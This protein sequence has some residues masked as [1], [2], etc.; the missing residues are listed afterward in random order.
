VLALVMFL[1][2]G[3]FCIVQLLRYVLILSG[4]WKGPI[5]RLYQ[6]YAPA[7]SVFDP[8][9]QLL[10]WSGALVMSVGLILTFVFRVE[11]PLYLIGIGMLISAFAL[12]QYHPAW[13]Y[14]S[15]LRLPAWDQQLRTMTTR[16]ERRHLAYMWLQLP[17][18][19]RHYLN[20]HDSAFWQ[21][22]ELV[23]LS[24][25]Q[26][27]TYDPRLETAIQRRSIRERTL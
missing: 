20:D 16:E 2:L 7:E 4:R 5:F 1:G 14:G 8:L 15:M 18:R 3:L 25:V 13:R 6:E 10:C 23:I 26:Q 21:W 12:Y 19:T 22:V 24:T 9:P 27:T 11:V 17:E